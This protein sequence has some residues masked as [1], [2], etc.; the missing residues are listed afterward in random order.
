MEIEIDRCCLCLESQANKIR[1]ILICGHGMDYNCFLNLRRPLCPLCRK[2]IETPTQFIPPTFIHIPQEND[3]FPVPPAAP[4]T[5]LLQRQHANDLVLDISELLQP[6]L[7]QLPSQWFHQNRFLL[8][9]SSPHP[10]RRRHQARRQRQRE[11]RRRH[12]YDILDD[13]E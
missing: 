11:I 2:E 1:I 10:R 3:D 12:R 9:E 7:N 8:R 13:L 4:S 6:Q 5:P